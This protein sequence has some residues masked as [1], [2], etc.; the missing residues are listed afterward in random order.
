MSHRLHFHQNF[1]GVGSVPVVAG[2][3]LLVAVGGSPKGP[4]P[5]SLL[6][7]KPDGTCIVALDKATGVDWVVDSWY[8]QMGGPPDIFLLK[9]WLPRGFMQSGALNS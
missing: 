7:A 2:D 8:A 3:L 4:R 5:L 9:D 6:D 1:F